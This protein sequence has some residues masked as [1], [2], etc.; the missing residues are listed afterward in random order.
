M[1]FGGRSH[2]FLYISLF[3]RGL[4]N[5]QS[6]KIL[7]PRLEMPQVGNS[8]KIWTNTTVP[9]YEQV[10]FQNFAFKSEVENSECTL[11]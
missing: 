11:S 3:H 5:L 2:L 6:N 7:V 8:I 1:M 9:N 4:S 10:A